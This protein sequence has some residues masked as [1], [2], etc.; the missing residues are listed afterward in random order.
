MKTKKEERAV[1]R[2]AI[3][4]QAEATAVDGTR[5]I[6]VIRDV[7][8]GDPR[9]V[10]RAYYIGEGELARWVAAKRTRRVK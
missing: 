4:D 1:G 6:G 8:P 2:L 5:L 10:A 3:G 9:K 7:H